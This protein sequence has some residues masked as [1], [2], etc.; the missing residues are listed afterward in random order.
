MVQIP[1]GVYRGRGCGIAPI[2]AYETFVGRP[3]DYV[4]DFMLETPTTWAQFERGA[5]TTT[6]DVSA[7]TGLLGAR[8]LAL[9]VPACCMGTTWAIEAA[10]TNDAHWRAL[11][12]SLVTAGLGNAVLRIGREF[13]GSWYNWK[14]VEGGQTN[15]I[16]GY[17]HIVSVLRGV[18]GSSF[19][20]NWNPYLGVGNLTAH[21]AESCYPGDAY[22]DEIGIDI[23]DYNAGSAYP[24]STTAIS[25]ETAADA[26]TT[27]M[28]QKVFDIMLTEW[29]SLRGWYGLARTHN[30]PLTFPEWGLRL[31]RDANIYTAGGDNAVLVAGMGKFIQGLST[32]GSWAA[33]W[34]DPAL[35]GMG[36]SDPDTGV[37]RQVATPMARAEFFKWFA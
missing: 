36:V 32:P 24:T 4:V 37:N 23:Y 29:D 11:G 3:V 27:V 17:S 20:F 6:V 35:G 19:R 14:V 5:L 1:L 25:S 2:N 10:G 26:I 21:G 34:E 16:A 28:Q 18:A 9:G 13:N 8:T 22:V 33:M 31:W 12:A 30:K 15:Y 7:W